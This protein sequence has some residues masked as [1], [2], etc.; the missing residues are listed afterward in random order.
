M[1]LS[2]KKELGFYLFIWFFFFFSFQ[3]VIK[4]S[5]NGIL[6]K[7]AAVCP[8][9]AWGFLLRLPLQTHRRREEAAQE[10]LIASKHSPTLFRL[11]NFKAW[12]YQRE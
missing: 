1:K 11:S 3:L 2:I 10:I 4:P 9:G 12:T 5:G 6:L 7:V 8:S